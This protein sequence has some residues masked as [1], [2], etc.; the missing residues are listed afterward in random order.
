[1]LNIYSESNQ[2]QYWLDQSCVID[3]TV[4]T[5]VRDWLKTSNRA[6]II[7]VWDTSET[8]INNLKFLASRCGLLVV[9]VPEF[10]DDW[11]VKELDLP[12][13][14]FFI[15]GT[16]NY[17]LNNAQVYFCPYFFSS[18]ADF[19]RAQPGILES[20]QPA[21]NSKF[22]VL[23]GR[24]RPHRDIVYNTLDRKKHVVTYFP[25]YTDSDIKQYNDGQFRWPSILP[26]PDESVDMTAHAVTVNGTVV[27]LSQ[28]IPAEIYNQTRY[29]LVAETS[30]E[31]GFSFYTEKIVKPI[32]AKRMFVV[33]SGQHY[34][35]NLKNLG[36]K[37]FSGIIDESYDD[38]ADH[39]Q[40]ILAVCR[41]VEHISTLD[42]DLLQ[43]VID[44][45]VKHNYQHMMSTEWQR[46]MIFNIGT[47]F[48]KYQQGDL[49]V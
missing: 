37:T 47:L 31:N 28:I 6:A 16:L 17:A 36:F 26:Q 15:S 29:T 18:T 35:R 21:D 38:I 13:V 8:D 44:P 12:N 42:P 34:L 24:R 19:Y 11:L 10:T 49:H 27:S 25:S 32:I 9:C 4:F 43:S 41:L 48:N 22:D 23:L 14:V 30:T 3:Y 46:Q 20:L 2:T 40:R 7:E 33:A 45:I 39:D 1:M 5:D